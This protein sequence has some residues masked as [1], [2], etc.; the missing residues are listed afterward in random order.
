[1]RVLMLTHNMAGIGGNFQRVWSMARGLAGRG[2]EVTLLA[3]R[4]VAGAR[5]IESDKSGIRLVQMGDLFPRRLRHGGLSPMDVAGRLAFI[6]SRPYDLVHG[7]DHRPAVSIPALAARRRWGTPYV[8][9]WADLWGRE[10]IAGERHSAGGRILGLLDDRWETRLHRAADAATVISSYLERR[11][12]ALGVPAHRVCRLAVGANED[13]I[14][15]R[16]KE[17]ARRKYGVPLGAKVLVH[18]GFAPYDRD[19]LFETMRHVAGAETAALL[20]LTGDDSNPVRKAIERA[21][22]AGRVRLFG[23][24]AFEDL[25]EIMACGDVM[26]LPLRD[27][28][29]NAARFPNRFGDYLAA[30]RPIATNQTG[31][32]GEIVEREQVGIVA[33]DEPR[34]FAGAILRLLDD[35]SACEAMGRRARG[36]A[37][38]RYSWKALVEPLLGFYKE[39]LD[40]RM[41]NT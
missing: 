7:M 16:A 40:A 10:G 37:E 1:M 39:L 2:V 35:P 23:L 32:V 33:P 14:Q 15:P 18:T 17:E 12:L 26:L 27:R 11:V 24:V 41:A 20:L 31:D 6:R 21:G 38:T 36:L 28:P 25:D 8:A 9:D 4:R 5:R 22:L 30:G 29:V 3:S 19:L 34:T 13:L